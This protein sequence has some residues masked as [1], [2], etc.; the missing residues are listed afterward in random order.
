MDWNET[1]KILADVRKTKRKITQKQ[2]ANLIPCSQSMVSDHEYGRTAP[3]LGSLA[4]WGQALD[5]VIDAT[6]ALGR[7]EYTVTDL[8]DKQTWT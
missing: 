8:K 3:T 5:V 2:L 1:R 7:I 6:V 4:E